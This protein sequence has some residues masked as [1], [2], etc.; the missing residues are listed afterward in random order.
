MGTW[1]PFKA[2]PI[3]QIA[4]APTID[5]DTCD[6]MAAVMGGVS[7]RLRIW[8]GRYHADQKTS[9]TKFWWRAKYYTPKRRGGDEREKVEDRFAGQHIRLY[10]EALSVTS[11]DTPHFIWIPQYNANLA[12]V[13]C[14][15]KKPVRYTSQRGRRSQ[16]ARQLSAGKKE[17]RCTKSDL[18]LAPATILTILQRLSWKFFRTLNYARSLIWGPT[19]TVR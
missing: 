18:R 6:R 8:F 15:I 19:M 5:F 11:H 13:R 9:K 7:K 3:R 10:S 16:S 4:A 2:M 17:N 1:G 14:P 12:G